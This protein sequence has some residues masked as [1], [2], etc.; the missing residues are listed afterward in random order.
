MLISCAVA[1]IPTIV[2]GLILWYFKRY[3]DAKDK[4]DAATE[5]VRVVNNVLLLKGISASISLG[6]TTAQAIGT[7]LWNHDMSEARLTALAVKKEMETFMN[8]QG[9]RNVV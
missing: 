2:C 9:S 8:E 4:K 7:E 3:F 5:R 6:L 1:M